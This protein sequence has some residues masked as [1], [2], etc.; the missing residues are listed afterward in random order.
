MLGVQ[1]TVYHL[2]HPIEGVQNLVSTIWTVSSLLVKTIYKIGLLA[3]VYIIDY[4]D[5]FAQ[6]NDIVSWLVS[7]KDRMYEVASASDIRTIIKHGT[8]IAVEAILFK[9]A[10]FFAY[11]TAKEFGPVI[12]KIIDPKVQYVALENNEVVSLRSLARSP[13]KMVKE[14]KKCK[15]CFERVPGVENSLQ[16]VSQAKISKIKHVMVEKHLWS[17][18]CMNPENWDNVKEVINVVIKKGKLEWVD[19]SSFKKTF[20]IRKELIEVRLTCVK[21]NYISFTNAWVTK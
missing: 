7:F 1:N 16:A 5:F 11:K 10:C 4:E 8:A 21:N 12:K 19:Y 9:K 6:K 2:L 17:R 18:V 20:L 14:L 15:K 3:H 13:F